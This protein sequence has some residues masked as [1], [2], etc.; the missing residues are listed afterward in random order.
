MEIGSIQNYAEIQLSGVQAPQDQDEVRDTLDKVNQ[1]ADAENIF[2]ANLL[3]VQTA[4]EMLQTIV[5]MPM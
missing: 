2:E 5:S 4:E 3:V 1:L